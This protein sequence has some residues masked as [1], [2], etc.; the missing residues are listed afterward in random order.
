MS[1]TARVPATL[2]D[3]VEVCD[4]RLIVPDP[5]LATMPD[6][7]GQLLIRDVR[8]DAELV[9]PGDLFIP[10]RRTD[11]TQIA[12]LRR[13]VR[14]GAAAVGLNRPVHDMPVPQLIFENAR[15]RV[16]ELAARAHDHASED[17]DVVA[18]TGTDG[19][20]TVTFLLDSIMRAAGRRSALAGTVGVWLDGSGIEIDQP[21]TATAADVQRLYAQ[22][23]DLRV[24]HLALE[25]TVG[26]IGGGHLFA[27]RIAV[28]AFTN[29][30]HEHLD[31]HG[32]MET[33]FESKA[34]LF[35]T[36]QP[37]HSVVMI[38]DEWGH[39]LL[40][41]L[42][43]ANVSTAS[44]HGEADYW[45]S[46]IETDAHGCRFRLHGVASAPIEMTVPLPGEHNVANAVVAAACCHRLGIG[47][48]DIAAGLAS[49]K[50]P[51]GRLEP[52]PTEAD[53]PMV[54]VDY[55]HTPQGIQAAVAAGEGAVEAGGKVIV[56]IGAGGDRDQ[57][58][59][60]DMGEAAS[61]ADV[62]VVTSDNP[63]SED[64]AKIAAEVASG[65]RRGTAEVVECPDRS[66]AISTAIGRGRAGDV[67]LVL[68]KGHERT[69]THGDTK[70][71]F[72]D[73]A[74]ASSVLRALRSKALER[75]SQ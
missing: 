41:K 30:A 58:K 46:D 60:A 70:V 26:G 7:P 43:R 52:V 6:D 24:D 21:S 35:T 66:N 32:S 64:P 34:P 57:S 36:C 40:E 53:E 56:V 25:A 12:Q 1:R 59:R 68:G 10:R 9:M 20:T 44:R 31:G 3:L 69:M 47:A 42:D 33:Y 14:R 8:C 19:K 38:D 49:A 72:S 63:R 54:Y 2:A 45:A 39:K 5:S 23:A 29:L 50:T 15:V 61:A 13:A 16:A 27:T 62:V 71:P 73:R 75:S 65:A 22:L 67:V 18:V 37:E 55:A 74:V 28:A 4:G 11:A 48:S 51:P 17:L